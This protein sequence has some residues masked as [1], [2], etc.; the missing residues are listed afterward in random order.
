[1]STVPVFLRVARRKRRT[2]LRQ[3]C[4]PCPRRHDMMV[5]NKLFSNTIAL[6]AAKRQG[7]AGGREFAVSTAL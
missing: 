3:L 1:M 5:A 7:A 6:L 2:P 4:R